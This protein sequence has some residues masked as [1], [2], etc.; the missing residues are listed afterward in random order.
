M[1]QQANNIFDEIVKD[2]RSVRTFTEIVPPREQVEEILNA[3]LL[4]PYAELGLESEEFRRFAVIPRGSQLIDRAAQIMRDQVTGMYEALQAEMGHNAYLKG[5]AEGFARRLKMVADGGEIGF[6]NA[7][8]FIVIGEKSGFPPVELRSLAHVQ[9][10]MWLKATA[11]GLGYRLV[12]LTTQMTDNEEFCALICFPPGVYGL[13]GCAIGY[14][15]SVPPPTERPALADIT[16]W[17]G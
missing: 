17:L 5:M 14:P 1:D 10:N 3:G 15:K 13:D 2:R 4:A 8:Y 11:L 6:E 12:S 9:Q 7:A 16:S